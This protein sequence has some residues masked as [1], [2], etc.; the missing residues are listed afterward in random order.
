MR[1]DSSTSLLLFLI[2]L[3]NCL[4]ARS[5]IDLKVLY[6]FPSWNFSNAPMGKP[7]PAVMKERIKLTWTRG[8]SERKIEREFD[9][10][11]NFLK[12]LE[13]R[14][15]VI[16]FVKDDELAYDYKTTYEKELAL[17]ADETKYSFEVDC[18]DCF[19]LGKTEEETQILI[20][21]LERD[22]LIIQVLLKATKK[23]ESFSQA[24]NSNHPSILTGQLRQNTLEQLI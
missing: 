6:T 12:N 4:E 8:D 19:D 7:V 5:R 9:Q 14:K 15:A 3:I 13:K 16:R 11:E 18:D 1:S 2:F 10:K 17:T 20:T 23:L 22:S 21:V 24:L